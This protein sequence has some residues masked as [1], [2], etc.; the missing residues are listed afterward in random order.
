MLLRFDHWNLGIGIYLRFGACDLEFSIL[1]LIFVLAVN[2]LPSTV[3]RFLF[4]EHLVAE[5]LPDRLVEGEAGRIRP[6]EGQ[7]IEVKGGA[8]LAALEKAFAVEGVAFG[9]KLDAQDIGK[10]AVFNGFHDFSIH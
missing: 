7:G 1:T 4:H 10:K 9:M 2:R 6:Q 3:C 5:P 8:G